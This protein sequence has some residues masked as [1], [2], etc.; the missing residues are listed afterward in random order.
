MFRHQHYFIHRED[1]KPEKWPRRI[2]V[3]DMS[4]KEKQEERKK[5]D[6]KWL[7]SLRRKSR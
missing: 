7:E 2:R 1:Y 6:Q 3:S 5:N 4:L